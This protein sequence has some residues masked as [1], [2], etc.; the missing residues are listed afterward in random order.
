MRSHLIFFCRSG[1]LLPNTKKLSLPNKVFLIF[2]RRTSEFSSSSSE[3][4][5]FLFL[6][7]SLSPHFWKLWVVSGSS[8]ATHTQSAPAHKK[9]WKN[10]FFA[11]T[12]RGEYIFLLY[13]LIMALEMKWECSKYGKSI[14]WWLKNYASFIFFICLYDC[15]MKCEFYD[16][17]S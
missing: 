6:L 3:R 12:K 15:N 11:H 17:S 7:L 1:W 8:C 13:V 4:R 16:F 14:W 10:I 5:L 9:S 2:H